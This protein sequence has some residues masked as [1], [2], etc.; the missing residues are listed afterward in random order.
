M[1]RRRA[2][3]SFQTDQMLLVLY[4]RVDIS[5]IKAL[6]LVVNVFYIVQRKF[7]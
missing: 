7:F 1:W 2:V 4:I 6:T 3:V 5:V